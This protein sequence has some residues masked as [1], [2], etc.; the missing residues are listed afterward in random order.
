MLSFPLHLEWVQAF[1]PLILHAKMCAAFC[2]FHKLST[3][4]SHVDGKWSVKII[5]R[6][7][8]HL[9]LPLLP[10]QLIWRTYLFPGAW[11]GGD[12]SGQLFLELATLQYTMCLKNTLNGNARSM[13]NWPWPS[14]WQ[15]QVPDP[16][17]NR[18]DARQCSLTHSPFGGI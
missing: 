14:G 13:E 8:S 10:R 1:L 17:I 18:L 9:S 15:Q 4:A 12:H 7:A 6:V 3:N 16:L 2:T 11:D 5:S